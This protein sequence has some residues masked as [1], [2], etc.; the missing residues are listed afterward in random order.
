MSDLAALGARGT[1]F[2]LTDVEG[3]TR[4]WE[5]DPTSMGAA[6]ARHD[7]ILGDVITA[8]GG[9]LLR[10]RGEG[11]SS[12][13]VFESAHSA[14]AAAV[15]VQQ[16][17]GSEPWPGQA[18]IRVRL[19]VHS[20]EAEFRDNDYYGSD[21]NRC[22]RLRALA[23]G[24]QCLVSAATRGVV[25]QSLPAG[26]WLADLGS[27]RLKDLTEP[28]RVYQVCHPDL[29]SEF[30]PLRGL[31]SVP[32][33]LPV[34]LTNFIGRRA[35]V[36][37]VSEALKT[38]RLVT[39]TGPGGCGKTRLALEVA[40]SLSDDFED[41][42]WFAD[43][44]ATS[45]PQLVPI[46]V[47]AAIGVGE[48][49]VR[50]A[51]APLDVGAALVEGLAAHLADR[52]TLV[53]MDNCEHLVSASAEFARTMLA[54]ANNLTILCTSREVLN[55]T[56][57]VAWRV[58]SLAVPTPR[59]ATTLREFEALDSVVLFVDRARR[60]E[61]DFRLTDR[62]RDAV[63]EICSRVDGLPLALELAAA[64]VRVLTVEQ[65]AE[66]LNDQF[67]LLASTVRGRLSRQATL[68]GAVD[69]SYD[70][71]EPSEARLFRQLAIFS[72]GWSIEGAEA[73]CTPEADEEVVELL[74][75]L[76]DKSLVARDAEAGGRFRLLEPLR[77]YAMEKL[78]EVDGIDTL[79]GRHL[80]WCARLAREAGERL[81]GQGQ[82]AALKLLDAELDN[83]RAAMEWGISRRRDESLLLAASLRLYWVYRSLLSEGRS[84]LE[85]ALDAC[86]GAPP[87]LRAEALMSAGR[88][89][90]EWGDLAAAR[91]H[92]ESALA[93]A[94]ENDLE[95]SAAYA[96]WYLAQQMWFE[97]AVDQGA[98]MFE[99]AVARARAVR[100]SYLIAVTLLDSAQY[101]LAVG[102]EAEALASEG[103]K[104]ARE[105]GDE[106]N[107]VIGLRIRGEVEMRAGRLAEAAVTLDD[108]V[109]GARR[110]GLL[111][112]LAD[113]LKA[114]G[115]LRV[116]TGELE[117]ARTTLLECLEVLS[118]NDNRSEVIE[119][120]E[121]VA[122][123]CAARGQKEDGADL[124]RGAQ[125]HRRV[126]G[127]RL[128]PAEAHDVDH[129]AKLFAGTPG[130]ETGEMT[131]EAIATPTLGDLMSRAQV[132]LQA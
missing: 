75:R 41:G 18:R 59:V 105:N 54:R 121:A 20:G 36:E 115:R 110:S 14:V 80:S 13:S 79:R 93:V 77:Q 25:A 23:A 4:L 46:A 34:Q 40:A 42:V 128:L 95:E 131:Q 90:M 101:A 55:V 117:A 81:K 132:C 38:A 57:E 73:V 83:L 2:M 16:R 47:A 22:A 17:L 86:D 27:H 118:E 125:A 66:R 37:A 106:R 1:T 72:G 107:V 112:P 129:L 51:E 9:S 45:D 76:V 12:F 58:P 49:I 28:E 30:P 65:I 89:A 11:D 5:R 31:E 92:L 114:S 64:R 91:H 127:L 3:S 29:P 84:W 123:L 15:A 8:H 119:V 100:S 94:T 122:G 104:A 24:G 97:G 109:A 35:D 99:T 74:S 33:N 70:L 52:R 88:L 60:H 96:T 116:R 26:T 19:A 68:R 98:E 126:A 32:N 130:E 124:F 48:R 87:V 113:A 78:L 71:L 62:N 63:A 111:G 21:V 85:E 67:R 6:M 108:A 61:R 10:A 56:G 7:Q 102:L 120:I 103:L 82:T 43:L 69:W 53:V 50:G 44:S 39:L